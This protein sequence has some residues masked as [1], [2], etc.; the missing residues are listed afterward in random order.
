MS[1]TMCCSCPQPSTK[2]LLSTNRRSATETNKRYLN[3]RIPSVN[4][5]RLLGSWHNNNAD[6]PNSI[7][8]LLWKCEQWNVSSRIRN[9]IR[10]RTTRRR[11]TA[12]VEVVAPCGLGLVIDRHSEDVFNK[13]FYEYFE[14]DSWVIRGWGKAAWALNFALLLVIEEQSYYIL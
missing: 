7:L 12:D 6:T 10:K 11:I 3:S 4:T 2:C 5:C 1:I 13:N 8:C 9:R 14:N